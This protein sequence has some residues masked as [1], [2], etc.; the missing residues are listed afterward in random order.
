MDVTGRSILQTRLQLDAGMASTE[1]DLGGLS[2]GTYL[3]HVENDRG[4]VSEHLRIVKQ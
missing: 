3:L 1:L 4:D 2:P